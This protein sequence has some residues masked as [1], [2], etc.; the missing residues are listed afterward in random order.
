MYSILHVGAYHFYSLGLVFGCAQPALGDELSARRCAHY[1]PRS[2]MVL[3][4]E[5]VSGASPNF[6][7]PSIS[8]CGQ[9]ESNGLP[10]PWVARN[11]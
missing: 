4:Q 3:L 11:L 10:F 8:A 1:R 5:V 9:R 6:H 2:S 7:R